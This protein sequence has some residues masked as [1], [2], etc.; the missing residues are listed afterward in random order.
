MN[1]DEGRDFTRAEI[2][3]I[4]L[5]IEMIGADHIRSELCKAGLADIVTVSS[6]SKGF[7][8]VTINETDHARWRRIRR[9]VGTILR[10]INDVQVSQYTA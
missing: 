1:S 8:T 4:E 2:E 6:P 3:E 9:K 5:V 10:G 7:H